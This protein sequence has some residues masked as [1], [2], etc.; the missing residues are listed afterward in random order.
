MSIF[1]KRGGAVTECAELAVKSGGVWK[2]VAD[3][4]IKQGGVWLPVWSNNVIDRKIE[5]VCDT[6][7]DLFEHT[8]EEVTEPVRFINLAVNVYD[9]SGA[10][11]HTQTWET[12]DANGGSYT[13]YD[14]KDSYGQLTISVDVATGK[15][16]YSISID[17]DTDARKFVLTADKMILVE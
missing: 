10:L 6:S 5:I 4:Y 9:G 15:V 8:Y 7:F 14:E 1:S 11:I 2:P 17:Y 12:F 16:S 13:I 3:A